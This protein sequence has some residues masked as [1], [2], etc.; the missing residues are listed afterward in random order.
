MTQKLRVGVI[1][2]NLQ[3]SWGVWAHLPALA[4]LPEADAVAV[5]TMHQE[6]ADAAA[7]QFGVPLAFGDPRR[8]IEHP[9]VDVIAICVRV[10]AH[11]ELVLQALDAGKHVYCEWPLARDVSEAEELLAAAEGA[12]VVHMVGLQS[13][14]S[15]VLCYAKELIE[16]GEIGPVRSV[17]LTHSSDWITPVYP[18]MAYLQDRS[19]GAHFLSIP[20]GHSIDALCWMLGDF[21]DPRAVIRT[22]VR[23]LP[24]VGGGTVERSSA[25]QILVAGELDSGAVASVRLSGASS[26]GTGVRMEISGDRGDLVIQATPGDRGIQMAN[27]TLFKTVGM[28]EL[29]PIAIPE[30]MFRVP[31]TLR[32]C[33]PMNVG[34]AYLRMVDAIAARAPATPDF[35]DAVRLHKLL[36]RVE[37]S[38]GVAR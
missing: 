7:A 10:P 16:A 1:G 15:P 26:P 5:A 33:P 34:E 37:A 14:S 22:T 8:L 21:K 13:R 35:A 32:M 12:G 4:A 25:D 18:S 6:S 29:E 20:G 2:A 36:D 24:L 11:R 38:A 19:S 3:G 30:R 9:E 17:A 28:A 31:P 23:E 27:L